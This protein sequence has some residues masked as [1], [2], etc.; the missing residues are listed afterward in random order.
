[1]K[2]LKKILEQDLETRFKLAIS[3]TVIFTILTIISIVLFALQSIFPGIAAPLIRELV[4]DIISTGFTISSAW[5][6]CHE[7]KESIESHDSTLELI[8]EIIND[9]SDGLTMYEIYN[10]IKTSDDIALK[11]TAAQSKFKEFIKVTFNVGYI[12]KTTFQAL[13]FINSCFSVAA[14]FTFYV[15]ESVL[16]K[17]HN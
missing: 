5:L 13:R 7:T 11:Y 10:L 12:S 9:F 4:L 1:M 6:T 2:Q 8:T 14:S 16:I 17:V 15:L 3:Y